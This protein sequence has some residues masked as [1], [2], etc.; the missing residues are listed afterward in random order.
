MLDC[1]SEARGLLT[2]EW[3][4]RVPSGL[5]GM[6]VNQARRIVLDAGLTVRLA[7]RDGRTEGP[8]GLLGAG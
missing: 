6:D 2:G 5:I 4:H 3:S 7:R 1:L 8:H